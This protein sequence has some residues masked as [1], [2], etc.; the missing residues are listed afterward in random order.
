M[1]VYY[2]AQNQN[3][4]Y[5]EDMRLIISKY[6]PAL[7]WISVIISAVLLFMP[8]GTEPGLPYVDKVAH[9]LL[10]GWLSLLGLKTYQRVFIIISS[11]IVYT[12]LAEF[13][14]YYF[15]TNRGLEFMDAVMGIVGIVVGWFFYNRKFLNHN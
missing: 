9:F 10:F 7:F 13:I 4:T 12:V 6:Y 5:S 15:V 14:Q 3:N 8:G 11:L 2:F 1:L